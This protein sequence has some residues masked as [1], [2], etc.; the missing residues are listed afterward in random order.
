MVRTLRDRASAFVDAS[1]PGTALQYPI[2]QCRQPPP[3]AAIG[4]ASRKPLSPV[5]PAPSLHQAT[6]TATSQQSRFHTETLET[7]CQDVDLRGVRQA[8]PCTALGLLAANAPSCI[9][10][11]SWP[12]LCVGTSTYLQPYLL[13]CWRNAG[14]R[15][16]LARACV[17][18]CV[19]SARADPAG[20]PA[21]HVQV[22]LAVGDAELLAGAHLR[23]TAGTRYGLVGRQDLRG[24]LHSSRPRLPRCPLTQ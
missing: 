2:C 10:A 14:S 20:M 11:S 24:A 19:A 9:Q 21:C 13:C 16:Q 4:A 12:C 17:D 23:L 6:I 22:T 1:P 18:P 15:L 5:A 7:P 8:A 3:A